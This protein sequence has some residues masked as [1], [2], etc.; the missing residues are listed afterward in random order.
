[1]RTVILTLNRSGRLKPVPNGFDLDEY[2]GLE[3]A[4]K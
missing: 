3:I 2:I 1:M 4:E